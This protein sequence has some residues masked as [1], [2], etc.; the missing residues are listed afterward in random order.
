MNEDE[1]L[2]GGSGGADC[3]E[4][5]K[6][7]QAISADGTYSIRANQV[8]LTSWKNLPPSADNESR[9]M[10]LA[11]GGL[12]GLFMDDGT[13]DVRGCKGVRITSGSLIPILNPIMSADSTDGIEIEAGEAQSI[14]MKRGMI[15]VV[16][17]SITMTASGI[18]INAGIL[19]TLTLTAGLSTITIGPSGITIIGIPLVQINPGPPA[20]P[21]P[22]LPPD[23]PVPPSPDDLM[24]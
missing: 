19:G 4:E 24:A 15:P 22:P 9:I 14:T 6:G 12:E 16:D 21:P 1:N 8:A 18:T 3:E 13:V 7:D 11:M 2:S 20:P 5:S 23:E 10:L 17:Q